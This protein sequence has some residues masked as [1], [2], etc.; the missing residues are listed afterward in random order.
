MSGCC[1]LALYMAAGG[2][3][4]GPT[5]VTIGSSRGELGGCLP[6]RMT[7]KNARASRPMTAM[8]PTAP[9]IIAAVDT[10]APP[11]A[12]VVLDSDE[13]AAGASA[14]ATPEPALPAVPVGGRRVVPPPIFTPP[15]ASGPA[16]APGWTVAMIVVSF[17]LTSVFV[18]P[19]CVT[20]LVSAVCIMV[21]VSALVTVVG[22]ALLM[23]VTAVSECEIG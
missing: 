2:A 7:M 13:V 15:P 19:F 5:E 11:T 21:L 4:T 8:P 17:A 22:G 23:M 16:V 9:P 6:R 1:A 3:P 12:A 10:P 14:P 18:S 20:V